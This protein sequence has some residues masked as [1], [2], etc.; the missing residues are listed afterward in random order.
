GGFFDDMF[1]D[2]QRPLRA[3]GAPRALS[4]RAIPAAAAQPWLPLRSLSLRWT[5]GPGDAHVGAAAT[6]TLEAVA[7]GATASQLP[8]IELPPIAGAQVFPDPPR[9]DEAFVDGRPQATVTRSFAIVPSRA[10]AL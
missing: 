5:Q 6:V 8:A 2:G 7:D 1:G 4:V 3:T 10:G 9:R